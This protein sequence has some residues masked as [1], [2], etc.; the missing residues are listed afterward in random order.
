MYINHSL[1]NQSEE[2]AD[3]FQQLVLVNHNTIDL[4]KLIGFSW[5]SYAPDSDEQSTTFIFREEKNELLVVKEGVVQKGHWEQLVLSNSLLMNDGQQE[6]LFNI[7]YF[8]NMGMILKKENLDEYL[9]LIKRSKHQT[10]EKSFNQV[11]TLFM[12]DYTKLQKQFD[13]INLE[14]PETAL[15]FE[16]IGEFREYRL[17]PYVAT[18]GTILIIIAIIIII[19]SRMMS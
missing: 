14:G 19:I 5:I 17:F 11:I 10:H 12:E 18:L 6:L 8:G 3:I 16:D 2:T 1:I 15:E 9:I 4:V 13:N 7:I